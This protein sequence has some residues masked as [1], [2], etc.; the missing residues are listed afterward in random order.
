MI[1]PDAYD[2][3]E[4]EGKKIKSMQS[5]RTGR[6]DPEKEDVCP[7]PENKLQ[8]TRNLHRYQKFY[9][10]GA[11]NS[12]GYLSPTYYPI[13]DPPFMVSPSFG[14][15]ILIPCIYSIVAPKKSHARSRSY[16]SPYKT[17]NDDESAPATQVKNTRT[18]AEERCK[19][20]ITFVASKKVL[21]RIPCSIKLTIWKTVCDQLI[22][23]YRIYQ[24]AKFLDRIDDV[25][26]MCNLALRIKVVI[27][28]NPRG[29][30]YGSNDIEISY[31]CACHGI[32]DAH[33]KPPASFEEMILDA[34]STAMIKFNISIR[35]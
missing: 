32:E 9:R 12:L 22:Q 1:K 25:L 7:E 14:S 4:L 2:F 21:L 35:N 18:T 6:V 24:E 8:R 28:T 19:V 26:N 23:S 31:T 16:R 3:D 15:E 10:I 29:F 5:P 30:V 17:P 27:E 20:A 13:L 11:K 34:P 33:K